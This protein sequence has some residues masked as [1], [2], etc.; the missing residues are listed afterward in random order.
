M[1]FRQSPGQEKWEEMRLML[2]QQFANDLVATSVKDKPSVNLECTVTGYPRSKED[3]SR[4]YIIGPAGL[5]TFYWNQVVHG[6]GGSVISYFYDNEISS[7]GGSVWDP[8]RM[9]ADAIKEIPRTRNEILSVAEIVL[10][11]PRIKGKIAVLYSLET[12]RIVRPESKDIWQQFVPEVLDY[13]AAAELTRV[14]V[15]VV[16]SREILNAPLGGYGLIILPHVYRAAP[17]VLQ[18]L[19][20]Y[21]RNGGS[22][23]LSPDSLRFDDEFGERL[24]TAEFL[25]GKSGAPILK[26]SAIVFEGEAKGIPE[27]KSVGLKSIPSGEREFSFSDPVHGYTFE[28]ATAQVLAKSAEQCAF[29]VQ[30][31]GRGHVYFLSREP[32]PES[33]RACINW[34]VKKCNLSADVDV[35]FTDDSKSDYVDTHLFTKDKRS[36]VYAINWGGGPR[37]AK[38]KLNG[39][40]HAKSV[41][42]DLRSGSYLALNGTPSP[43]P[44]EWTGDQLAQG[45]PV[46]LPSQD[47]A[48]LLIEESGIDALPLRSLTAEQKDVL[49]WLYRPSPPS[50]KRVLIDGSY[51]LEGRV[52]KW[53]MPTAVKLLEDHGF[54][55]DSLCQPL[56]KARMR[57]GESVKPDKLENYQVFVLTGTHGRDDWE[58]EDL[59]I[60]VD[61]VKNGGGLLYCFPT[62]HSNGTASKLLNRFGLDI[63]FANFYDPTANILNEPLYVTFSNPAA[64]PA[65]DGVKTFQS[66]GAIPILTAQLKENFTVLFKGGPSS[67][68]AHPWGDSNK[69][70]GQAVAVAL[71][72]SKGRVIAI[73]ADSWLRPDDLERGDNKAFFL[74]AIEWLSHAGK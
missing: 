66:A 51:T 16:T 9:S 30:T 19:S 63:A 18:K 10:P 8:T 44:V 73:G 48:V 28:P 6:V 59:K 41:L 5:R 61:Y 71:E 27:G 31:L 42:R 4:N 21:V 57:N 49:A 53:R 55:V 47:P 67:Y 14:P 38:L 24:D 33:R 15:D 68:T 37:P 36:V 60:A 11:R 65:T 58:D 40:S 22:V 39:A 7:G 26:E 52:H 2:E 29:S 43:A 20:E 17:G 50:D 54:E 35:A 69:S 3:L 74:K 62:D 64:H 13:Y 45:I 1:L 34:V 25:G 46:S 70:P 32:N 12:A 56:R 23:L 72:V